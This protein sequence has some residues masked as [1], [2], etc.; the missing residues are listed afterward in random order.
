VYSHTKI[1]R[2]RRRRR[3]RRKKKK[4]KKKKKKRSEE[5]IYIEDIIEKNRH[6]S[7]KNVKSEKFLP[8]NI[9]EI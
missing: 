5:R 2:R 9:W 1:N 3:R 6:T 7:L 4:K 8:Q